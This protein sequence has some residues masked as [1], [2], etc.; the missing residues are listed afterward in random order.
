MSNNKSEAKHED[1][2]Q[3]GDSARKMSPNRIK[4]PT[5]IPA[6]ERRLVKKIVPPTGRLKPKGTIK[7]PAEILVPERRLIKKHVPQQEY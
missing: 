4:H 1:L 6:P 3:K 5:E 2:P 7:N